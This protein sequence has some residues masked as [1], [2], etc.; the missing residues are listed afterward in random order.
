M[1]VIDTSR[2]FPNAFIYTTGFLAIKTSL[3][4]VTLENTHFGEAAET[5]LAGDTQGFGLFIEE[6]RA[7]QAK[8]F[9]NVLGPGQAG[10]RGRGLFGQEW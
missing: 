5:R 2:G 8:F 9:L 4:H 7:R 1:R 3:F 10:R 6:N